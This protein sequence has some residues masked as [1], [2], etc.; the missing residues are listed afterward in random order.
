MVVN[1]AVREVLELARSEAAKKG[2]SIQMEVGQGLPL[3]RGDRVQLQQ[4]ILNLMMNAIEAMSSVSEGVRELRIGTETEAAGGVR[5][6]VRDTGPG[7]DPA[8]LDRVFDR[9]YTTKANG[10]GMGLAIC[11]SIV[12]AHGGRMWAAVNEPRGAAFQFTL[13]S[14]G[15][16][17]QR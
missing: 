8:N 9:F 5:V 13:P 3:V 6:T 1:D 7:L 10:L 12:E 4:V 14:G 2:V 15:E 17:L 16:E 11:R